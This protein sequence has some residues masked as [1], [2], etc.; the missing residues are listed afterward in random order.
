M[1]RRAKQLEPLERDEARDRQRTKAKQNP[2]S[3]KFSEATGEAKTRVAAALGVS[4][5]TLSKAT[6]VVEAAEREP[7]RYGD[8]FNKS[9]A[10]TPS[11]AAMRS[12]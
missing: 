4:A 5:P 10:F 1:V 6:A 7:E 8:H 2:A 12:S 11:T 9:R 3:E